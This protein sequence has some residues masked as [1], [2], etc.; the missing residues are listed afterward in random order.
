[1]S[2]LLIIG[3]GPHPSELGA[4]ISGPTIRLRQFCEPLAAAGHELHLV[5]LEN[6]RRDALEIP[7]VQ[8]AVALT[9]ED[10]QVPWK[11]LQALRLPEIDAVF[12]VGSL[13]PVA[14][15]ARVAQ[16]VGKPLWVDFFGDPLAEWHAA[17]SRPG[18]KPEWVLRDQIWKFVREGLLA[19]DQFSSVSNRQ[20]DAILGQLLLLCRGTETENAG[21]HLHTIEC[22]VPERW[23]HAVAVPPFP[24]ALA[25]RGF[26]PDTKFLFVGGSWTP[27]LNETAMGT[28]I[29]RMLTARPDWQLIVRGGPTDGHARLIYETFFAATG[30]GADASQVHDV[31]ADDC[32]EDELL[33]YAMG[34]VL[35]DRDIPES[36]LGSRNRL[37]SFLHWG[38]RALVSPHSE[39]ARELVAEN[40]ALAW[41]METD[42]MIREFEADQREREAVRRRGLRFL[43]RY[44]F[45]QTLK[46]VCEWAE[47]PTRWQGNRHVGL[48]ASWAAFPADPDVLMR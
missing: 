23:T 25:R 44:T 38:V 30:D 41:P 40:L 7:G 36:Y 17:F 47:N 13:M 11:V 21:A 16:R 33:A 39:I 32:R 18:V 35:L 42:A 28:E 14:A 27:W 15:A 8:S 24:E 3:L 26:T 9:P 43:E 48:Q 45:E 29:E 19:G 20:R 37:L 10:I 5:M 6:T 2:R 4:A 31:S 46:P 34:A 12:G 1:M 22:A